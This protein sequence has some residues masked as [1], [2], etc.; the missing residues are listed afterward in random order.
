M[1]VL[2]FLPQLGPR[3]R[4]LAHA[5]VA[6]LL[7]VAVGPVAQVAGDVEDT[8]D[9]N[10]EF[11]GS[12]EV[13]G[14][15]QVVNLTQGGVLLDEPGAWSQGERLF[16][17]WIGGLSL[18][19]RVYQLTLFDADHE[20]QLFRSTAFVHHAQGSDFSARL[21]CSSIPYQELMSDTAMPRPDW[22]PAT[23]VAGSGLILL[24]CFLIVLRA[25]R[26]L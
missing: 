11:R 14:F 13:Q 22:V 21:N 6:L 4:L 3:P 8:I 1:G 17:T 2:C 9:I 15:I 20:T 18:S 7:L 5:G 19:N 16:S 24:G 12:C 26:S 10:L 25:R 23:A